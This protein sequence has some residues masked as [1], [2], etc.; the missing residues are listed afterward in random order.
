LENAAFSATVSYTGW[1]FL[2]AHLSRKDLMKELDEGIEC[3]IETV[4]FASNDIIDFWRLYADGLFYKKQLPGHATSTPPVL[5][6]SGI[7]H[8]F[9]EAIDCMC[10]LYTPL[11]STTERVELCL[12]VTGTRNRI[13]IWDTSTPIGTDQAS[14][15][16]VSVSAIHSLADWKAGLHDHVFQMTR[17]LLLP[18][19]FHLEDETSVRSII[20]KL[21]SRRF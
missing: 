21:F 7:V 2:L 11:C 18:F 1:P 8:Q 14:R 4:D 20:E 3:K 6:G 10:R 16:S 13:H 17:D 19:R 9:A 5:Y 12:T 15:P